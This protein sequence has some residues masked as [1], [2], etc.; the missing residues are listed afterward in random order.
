MCVCVC[1]CAAVRAAQS[2]AAFLDDGGDDSDS[3]GQPRASS[4]TTNPHG[5][6]SIQSCLFSGLLMFLYVY[7][8]M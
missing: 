6:I 5:T 2:M 1:V 7:I 8:C 3:D 4:A